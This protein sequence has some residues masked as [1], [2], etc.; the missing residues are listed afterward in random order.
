MVILLQLER[1]LKPGQGAWQ[2]QLAHTDHATLSLTDIC[3]STADSY[4]HQSHY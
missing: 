2:M 3:Y 4:V 1:W